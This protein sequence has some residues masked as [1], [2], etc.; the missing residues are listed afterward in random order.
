MDGVAYT[1]GLEIDDEHKEIHFSLDYINTLSS[2]TAARKRD[3]MF[4]VLVHETVH[5]WQWNGQGTAPGGLIEGMADF[6]RLKAGLAPPHWTRAPGKTWDAGYAATA[7]FLA[8]LEERVG[9]GVVRRMNHALKHTYDEDVFWNAVC[10]E[11]I[12]DLWE[13]YRKQK[14]ATEEESDVAEE[15]ERK[16]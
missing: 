13:Q 8:W 7:Y 16:E 5:V 2:A 14:C 15:E 12:G 11:S 9:A 1:T 3:E 10:G 6:V 4:G